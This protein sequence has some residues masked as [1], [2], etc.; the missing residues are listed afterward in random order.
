MLVFLSQGG[1]LF[2]L[3]VYVRCFFF[4]QLPDNV[5]R[6]AVYHRA[7]RNGFVLRD[8]RPGTNDGFIAY[9]RIVHE[10]RPHAN[11]TALANCLTMDNRIVSNQ[12]IVANRHW[13]VR[14]RMNRAIILNTDII[15]NG[16]A[17]FISPNDSIGLNVGVCANRHLADDYC[18]FRNI[19]RRVNLGQLPFKW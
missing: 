18:R 9:R 15:A 7:R 8:N 1:I 5:K 11:Q 3:P 10:D 16:D 17:V 14:F 6:R 19:R 2:G 12:G 4:R 13:L